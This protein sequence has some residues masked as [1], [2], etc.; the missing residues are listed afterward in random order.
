MSIF[1]ENREKLKIIHKI[2]T[3]SEKFSLQTKMEKKEDF[4]KMS[5]HFFEK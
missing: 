1:I 5:T 4:V 3:R 2:Y